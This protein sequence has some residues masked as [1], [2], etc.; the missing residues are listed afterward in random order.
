MFCLKGSPN[1]FIKYT[2]STLQGYVITPILFLHDLQTFTSTSETVQGIVEGHSEGDCLMKCWERGNCFAVQTIYEGYATNNVKWCML[3]AIGETST[4]VIER[5]YDVSVN[6][7]TFKQIFLWNDPTATGH[8]YLTANSLRAAGN[9]IPMAIFVKRKSY[10]R[11]LVIVFHLCI[12]HLV[13]FL[14][15]SPSSKSAL[16]KDPYC[17]ICTLNNMTGRGH[18]KFRRRGSAFDIQYQRK[19]YLYDTL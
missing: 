5:P 7:N 1:Q 17:S 11:H 13:I 8:P 14:G 6:A 9:T 3:L 15:E 16:F 18:A 10:M 19:Q 2:N 12:R 4:Q